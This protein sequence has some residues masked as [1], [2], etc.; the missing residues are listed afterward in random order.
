MWQGPS[1]KWRGRLAIS[2]FLVYKS[3][4]LLRDQDSVYIQSGKARDTHCEYKVSDIIMRVQCTYNY[5]VVNL[6]ITVPYI[7]TKLVIRHSTEICMCNGL[8]ADYLLYIILLYIIL[9][10]LDGWRFSMHIVLYACTACN[11]REREREIQL[12]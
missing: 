8:E 1:N 3:H 2:H 9:D 5:V 4:L 6:I 11:I 10:G 7:Y 12:E